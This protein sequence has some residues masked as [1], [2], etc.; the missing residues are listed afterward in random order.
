MKKSEIY[1]KAQLAVLR[2]TKLGEDTALTIIAELAEQEKLELFR[3]KQIEEMR[4][5]EEKKQ[6][7]AKKQAEEKGE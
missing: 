7:E 3:E 2:D 1:H 5:A 6:A 4:H